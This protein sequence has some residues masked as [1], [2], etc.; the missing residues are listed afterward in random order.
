M[1]ILLITLT[2]VTAG[3]LY[4]AFGMLGAKPTADT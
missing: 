3:A 2:C 4:A 1:D